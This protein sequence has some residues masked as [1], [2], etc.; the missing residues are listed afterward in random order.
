MDERTHEQANALALDTPDEVYTMLRAARFEP[1]DRGWRD[2]DDGEVV[3]WGEALRR[4]RRRV[5]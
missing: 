4:A 1:R 5:R 2:P 3:P